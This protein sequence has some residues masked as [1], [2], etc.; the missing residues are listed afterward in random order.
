[1]DQ[2]APMQKSVI[3]ML[4]EKDH[5]KS[6]LIGSLLIATGAATDE[7]ISEAK[8]YSKGGRFEP[9]YMLD[10]FSEERE[11]EMTIET[12]RAEIVYKRHLFELIDVPGHLELIKNMMS[13]A[14]HGE[15]AVLVVSMKKGEGLR[16]QTKRHLYISNLLG[17]RGLVVAINK[18]DLAGYSEVEFEAMKKKVSKY[19]DA[20]GFSRPVSYVPV[21]AYVSDNLVKPSDNMAWYRGKPLIDELVSLADAKPEGGSGRG[22]RAIVQDVVVQDGKEMVFCFVNSGSVR[23]GETVRLQPSGA[24]STVTE[25]YLKGERSDSAPQGSNIAM[26]MEGKAEVRRGFVVS[27]ADHRP[28]SLKKFEAL[29]FFIRAAPTD[30]EVELKMNNNAVTARIVRIGKLISPITGKQK[31]GSAIVQGNAARVEIELG[32]DYPVERFADY[33]ELGRFALY[34]GGAFCGIGIVV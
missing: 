1:M 22:L 24:T 10:S 25:I 20:V 23:E 26:V 32:E 28:H 13:G 12:T 34:S 27:D 9:G 4:G 14:S 21:S 30:K 7:R 31:P 6:T 3:T 33:N 8:R 15:I 11:R 2:G 5:G 29:A 16:P 18:M 17:I 19:L